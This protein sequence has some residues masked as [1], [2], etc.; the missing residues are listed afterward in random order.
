LIS[1]NELVDMVA[2][3][4]GKRIRKRHDLTKPQG[5]RG[6]N[7]DLTLMKKVL[8]WQPE[9]SL[10]KGLEKTYRWIYEELKKAGRVG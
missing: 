6:R 5:V 7:A 3:I 10:E 8:G 9:V 1:I 2:K 4:A